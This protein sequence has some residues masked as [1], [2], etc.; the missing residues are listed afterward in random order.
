MVESTNDLR[1]R[2]GSRLILLDCAHLARGDVP[3]AAVEHM[4]LTVE[5]AS[6]P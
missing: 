3:M 4:G 2:R 1:G 5:G 6:C